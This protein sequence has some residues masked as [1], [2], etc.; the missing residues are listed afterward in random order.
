MKN[1]HQSLKKFSSKVIFGLH[2]PLFFV[3]SGYFCDILKKY[4]KPLLRQ[5]FFFKLTPSSYVF[6]T[7]SGLLQFLT[8]SPTDLSEALV[9]RWG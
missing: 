7:L 8:Q 1:S 4:S 3:V 5:V 2:I 9:G 6:Q